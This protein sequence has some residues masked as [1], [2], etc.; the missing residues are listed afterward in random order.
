MS[1]AWPER[2]FEV[3]VF[4][5]NMYYVILI[6]NTSLHR[7]MN[8]KPTQQPFFWFRYFVLNNFTEV[9]HK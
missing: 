6:N 4:T 5:V 7:L 1:I 2:K 8:P 3:T 9:S